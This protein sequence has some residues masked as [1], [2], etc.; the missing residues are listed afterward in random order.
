MIEVAN[1]Y[2]VDCDGMIWTGTTI[3][4]NK[5][6]KK[7]LETRA[8]LF[9]THNT[10]YAY[11]NN[12]NLW[13][14]KGLSLYIHPD[15]FEDFS[16]DIKLTELTEIN[17]NFFTA[18]GLYIAPLTKSYKFPLAIASNVVDIFSIQPQM[19][20]I[21]TCNLLRSRNSVLSEV[22]TTEEIVQAEEEFLGAINEVVEKYTA[23]IN[24]R[25]LLPDI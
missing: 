6:A 13:F 11:Y 4:F 21:D 12:L 3:L 15:D 5:T 20:V 2:Q 22:L 16:S 7:C 23:I 25:L 9:I 1:K 14:V 18:R 19:P 10:S 24:E 17:K 8:I